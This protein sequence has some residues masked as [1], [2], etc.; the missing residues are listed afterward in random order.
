[1]ERASITRLYKDRSSQETI[2][3]LETVV[4]GRKVRVTVPWSK[5]GVLALEAHGLN[6]RCTLYGVFVDCIKE[7]GASFRSI[8]V[9][10]DDSQ[11]VSCAIS[12][13]TGRRTAW[14]TADVVDLVAFALH[15]GLPIYVGTPES[16]SADSDLRETK[17]PAVFAD[18]I[19]DILSNAPDPASREVGSVDDAR[20]ED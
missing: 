11:D 7:L 2:M 3:L 20:D 10:C 6:D 12:L 8:V 18:A 13:F 19:S 14:I 17:V 15:V 1:M 16:D 4:S 9:S 5:A